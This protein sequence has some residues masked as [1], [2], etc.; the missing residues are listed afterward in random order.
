MSVDTS[1][2]EDVRHRKSKVWLNMLFNKEKGLALCKICLQKQFTRIV[3]A[4]NGSTKTASDHLKTHGICDDKIVA[5]I[6]GQKSCK[7]DNTVW[8]LP[9]CA[10]IL[11]TQ[12]SWVPKGNTQKNPKF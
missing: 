4:K 12:Y 9:L 5:S 10:Q 7:D 1:G 8:V 11:G 6:P 3:Y 2:F